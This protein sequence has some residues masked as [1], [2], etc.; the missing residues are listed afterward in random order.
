MNTN[1]IKFLFNNLLAKIYDFFLNIF[2][3][4]QKSV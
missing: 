1:G 4:E 2:G 3:K